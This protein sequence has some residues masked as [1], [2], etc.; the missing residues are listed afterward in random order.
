MDSSN[1]EVLAV[2]ERQEWTWEKVRD[3][4]KSRSKSRGK[5]KGRKC[6]KCHHI[7]SLKRNYQ[8]LKH[9]KGKGNSKECLAS[10]NAYSSIDSGGDLL[11]IS[12]GFSKHDKYWTLDLACSHYYTSNWEWFTTYESSDRE[13][14]N[15]E[16]NHPCKVVGISTIK[17][18]MHDRFIW[19][20]TNVWHI[21]ELKKILVSLGYIEK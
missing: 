15:L 20:L 17:L 11:V 3:K 2:N 18:R 19:T 21:L 13:S 4:P 14:M 9:E 16:D 8:L 5:K 10:S 6:Y 7:S 12:D 1:L